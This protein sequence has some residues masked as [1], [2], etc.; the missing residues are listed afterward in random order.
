MTDYRRSKCY[1]ERL[2]KLDADVEGK[3]II[4]NTASIHNKQDICK[5][6]MI[7]DRHTN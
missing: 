6:F 2:M 5:I 4:Q 1:H 7:H 3:F